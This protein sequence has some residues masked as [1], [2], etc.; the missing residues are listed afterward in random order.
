FFYV[1]IFNDYVSVIFYYLYVFIFF[2]HQAF[3]GFLCTFGIAYQQVICDKDKVIN[4]V[5]CYH[6]YKKLGEC[7]FINLLSFSF[8]LFCIS[9]SSKSL[10]KPYTAILFKL[11]SESVIN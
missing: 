8:I 6:I 10:V 5:G 2:I 9:C 7:H 3:G 4:E 1:F 11:S